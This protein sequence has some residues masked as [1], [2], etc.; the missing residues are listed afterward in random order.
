MKKIEELKIFINNLINVIEEIKNNKNE[1][2]IYTKV[3]LNNNDYYCYS[4]FLYNKNKEI[5]GCCIESKNNIKYI[6]Y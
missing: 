3:I 5:V 1:E 6:L 4:N 2:K